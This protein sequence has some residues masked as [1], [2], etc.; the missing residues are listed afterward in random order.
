MAR[1]PRQEFPAPVAREIEARAIDEHG[2]RRCEVLACHCLVKIHGEKIEGAR[3]AQVDHKAAEWTKRETPLADRPRLTANDGWLICEVCHKAK[4]RRETFERMRTDGGGKQH[5]EHLRAM[6]AK[7]EG[8]EMEP[9]RGKMQ[10]R[11][12]PKGNRKIQSRGFPTKA[13]RRQF[14]ET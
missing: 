4:S 3:P 7:L 5:A 10:G 2:V 14:L 1:S 12:F 9:T 13:E 11:G 6:A 8:I